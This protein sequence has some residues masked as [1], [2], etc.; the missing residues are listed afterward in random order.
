MNIW[1]QKISNGILIGPDDVP[2]AWEKIVV[3]PE[4]DYCELGSVIQKL[5]S[6]GGSK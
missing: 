3:V 4:Y 5:L 1:I 6:Q 2:F